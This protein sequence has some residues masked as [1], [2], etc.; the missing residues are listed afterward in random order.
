MICRQLGC[1]FPVA[2]KDVSRE[3]FFLVIRRGCLNGHDVFEACRDPHAPEERRELNHG[4]GRFPRCQ[5][6]SSRKAGPGGSLCHD[7]R[8]KRSVQQRVKR[9]VRLPGAA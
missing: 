5:G 1:S 3:G 2:V 7:C 8:T 4:Q 9:Q 6:C